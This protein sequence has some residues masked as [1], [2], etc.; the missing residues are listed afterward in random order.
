VQP[1]GAPDETL[2]DVLGQGEL[3]AEHLADG[4]DEPLGGRA[5]ADVPLG[6][7]A[8]RALREERLLAHR[9]HEH[10]QVGAERTDLADEIDTVAVPQRDVGDDEVRLR[11]LDE[12]HRIGGRRGLA[13]DDEVGLVE[14]HVDDP[15]AHERMILDHEDPGLLRDRL[16]GP[17]RRLINH[18]FFPY[19]NCSGA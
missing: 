13:A 10:G 18:A 14:D 7:G 15:A 19:W 17:F 5:L 12:L 2:R 9:Q 11:R 16:R 3:A 6:A 1:R 8:D 4:A